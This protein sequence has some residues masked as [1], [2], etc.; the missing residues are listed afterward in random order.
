MFGSLF[1][2]REPREKIDFS[3]FGTDMHSHLIPG[4]DDGAPTLEDSI[5]LI[6]ELAALGF[7]KL[8]TTPHVMNDYFRNTPEI[9]MSGLETVRKAIAEN[10]INISIDAAAEYYLDDGLIEKIESRNLLTFGDRYLLFEISYV[11]QPDNLRDAIFRMQMAGYKPILAHPER[12]PFWFHDF[13]HFEE[14]RDSGVL[15]QININSLTGYYS[16][17]AKKI[18]EKL[19]DLNMVDMIGTDTHHL[20]H[21]A[22][23]KNCLG[24]KYFRKAAELDVRNKV[25]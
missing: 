9:I 7:K 24:E 22:Q 21:I 1:K 12:Y 19:I 25:L 23:L 4:I 3:A 16:P 20:R 18:A 2:K 6:K 17:P 10:G 15:L 14:M 13:R 5:V 8:I 11:N